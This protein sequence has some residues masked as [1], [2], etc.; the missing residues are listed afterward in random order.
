MPIT[1]L[2][3]NTALYIIRPLLNGELYRLTDSD[4][5]IFTIKT[6]VR[7]NRPVFLRKLYA[8]DLN[9]DAESPE[10]Q[11]YKLELTPEETRKFAAITY[12][13]DCV[14]EFAG[15]ERYTFIPPDDF[16]VGAVVNKGGTKCD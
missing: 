2:Q 12:K 9:D 11:G 15:G 14:I 13:Y 10:N 16:I 6:S 7:S 8:A 3:S 1:I 5:I 4:K